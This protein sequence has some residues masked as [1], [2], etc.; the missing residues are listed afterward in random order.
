MGEQK[1]KVVLVSSKVNEKIAYELRARLNAQGIEVEIKDEESLTKEEAQE[2]EDMCKKTTLSEVIDKMI[3]IDAENVGILE[4]PIKN[5]KIKKY[6]PK[7]IGNESKAK[8]KN[9]RGRRYGR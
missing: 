5:K 3:K 6:M 1:K 8:V 2:I 7:K 4:D 9:V